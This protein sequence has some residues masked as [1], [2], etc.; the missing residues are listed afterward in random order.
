MKDKKIYKVE[1]IW[2]D[3]CKWAGIWDDIETVTDSYKK[4]GLDTMKTCGYLLEKTKD[5]VLVCLSLHINKDNIS[6]R[7]ADF[8]V[9]PSGCIKSIKKI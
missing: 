5:Y 4:D 7:G 1:V 9:I 8:F 6:S 3:S 2:Q